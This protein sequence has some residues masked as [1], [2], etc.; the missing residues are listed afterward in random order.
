MEDKN[1]EDKDKITLVY[2]IEKYI[3]IRYTLAIIFGIIGGVS[4][5]ILNEFFIYLLHNL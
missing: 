2:L 5:I 3:F 1:K 4:I